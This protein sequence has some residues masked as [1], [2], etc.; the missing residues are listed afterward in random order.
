MK[1]IVIALLMAV[2]F[3]GLASV[4]SGRVVVAEDTSRSLHLSVEITETENLSVLVEGVQEELGTVSLVGTNGE[5]IYF[6]FLK[7]GDNRIEFKTAQLKQ[8]TYFVKIQANGEIRMKKVI[9]NA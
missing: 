2:S 6:E 7:L 1:T 9:I 5:S 8:G 4:G 3:Q